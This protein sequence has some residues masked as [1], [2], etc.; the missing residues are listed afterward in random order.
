MAAVSGPVDEPADGSAAL[1]PPERFGRRGLVMLAVASLALSILM[2][3]PL[4]L[5]LNRDVA[6]DAGDPL[7]EAWQVAWDGHAL[8]HQPL[9]V[10]ESNAFWPM[11]DSLA[12]EDSL[13][14]YSPAG[15]IGEGTVAA[16]IRYDVLYILAYGLAFAGA[17]LLAREIGVGAWAAGVAGAAYAYAP[18]RLSQNGHLHVVSSGGL[19]LAVFLL[20]RGYRRRKPGMVLAG[21]LVAA[22]Q[23]SLGFTLGLQLAY[24]IA[25]LAVVSAIRWF[26]AGRPA[27]GRRV[28]A[29]SVAGLVMFAGWS[30]VQAQ[31]YLR[32][33]RDHPEA[34]R[35]VADVTFFS[36]PPRGL[37]AAPAN[38]WIWGDATKDTRDGLPWAPEQ[39]LFPGVV[40]VLLALV[41]LG[42]RRYRWSLRAGLLAGVIVTA[43]AALGFR[44]ANGTFTYGL[45]YHHAPGWQSSRTPGRLITLAS[46]GLG[47]LGAMGTERLIRSVRGVLSTE[48]AK[49]AAAIAVGVALTACVL[50]E[51]AGRV[52][53]P[54]VPTTP[55][56]IVGVAAP[57]L[58]LPSDYFN[59]LTYMYWSTD[60]FPR[61][62]NGTA[63][64]SPAFQVRLLERVTS[65]PDAA[66]VRFLKRIGFSS[67]V[68]HPERAL[69]TPW[70]DAAS[71]PIDGLGITRRD[72]EGAVVYDL[73]G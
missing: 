18:W 65:F 44:L 35:S 15:L 24:L 1:E 9:H 56:G 27:I 33:L 58:H 50:V 45:L 71:K 30:A 13:L 41:A 37:L 20:L 73:R 52:P 23:V 49:T 2:S 4:V 46:L 29:A 48:R 70:Q 12:F 22:W 19:P 34:K 39:T 25:V 28:V 64:F 53:H 16:L 11:H 59:D 38:D 7:I 55:Q 43:A 5:H 68:L 26:A 62:A 61:I 21:W 67:V 3:W 36:P 72:Q 42:T 32:V 14:G 54:A 8:S 66:S 51:G 6:N 40:V 47:L 17:F 57:Q 69:G 10:F 63:V 31:P 60:G